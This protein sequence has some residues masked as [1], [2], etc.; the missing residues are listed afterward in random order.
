MNK[1]IR[2]GING[3]GRI[4]RH[5]FKM[6]ID[7]PLIEL[8][9]IN[10]INPDL[11][12]WSYTLNYDSIYGQSKHKTEI[13]NKKLICNNKSIFTSMCRDITKV[14][15]KGWGVKII[16]DA[17]GV[18]ENT[19]KASKL[20]E[21]NHA[22]KI[23][24]TNSPENVDFT[25]ILGVNENKYNPK[26]HHLIAASIC[27]ATAIAPVSKL[28]DSLYKIKLGYVTTL[29]P[30][31]SYQN[32]MDGPSSSWSVPGEVYHHYA[33]G[34]SAIGNMIPKP[35]S[36]MEAVFKVLP[37]ITK[38]IGSFSYRTPTQIIGS[39]DLSFLVEKSANKQELVKTFTEFQNSQ[40]Y[41]ILKLTN[42]PLVS[43]DY[44]GEEYSAIVD[45]RW[46]DVLNYELIK[47]VLWYDNE[48]GYCCNVINQIK[49]IN[50][51]ISNSN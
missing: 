34:R 36:A 18:L 43:M 28:I 35:T 45:T 16:I 4:G 39:A 3:L 32:I 37:S 40:K 48:Y 42:E 1:K 5:I 30:W 31:L 13:K 15:W 25:M 50:N 41:P 23:I 11:N 9:G 27:D 21:D 46:L 8:V 22:E 24:F 12:N 19:F 33:L 38:N 29:H 44:V 26:K 51:F 17:S 49:Y 7:D 47:I 10:E 14:N 2:V 20:I 6:C